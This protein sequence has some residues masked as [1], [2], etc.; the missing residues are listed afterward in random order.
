MDFRDR[1]LLRK[2]AAVLV[3]KLVFLTGLWWGFVREQRVAV[4]TDAAASQMLGSRPVP[5]VST[6]E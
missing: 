5:R 4:D 1:F 6:Q 3:I 2:L